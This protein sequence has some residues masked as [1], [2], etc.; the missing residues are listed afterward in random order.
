M[1]KYKEK[2]KVNKVLFF[3][4]TLSKLL[5]HFAAYGAFARKEKLE[6]Y[7][8]LYLNVKPTLEEIFP[9]Y[10]SSFDKLFFTSMP[11]VKTYDVEEL[12]IIA[13]MYQ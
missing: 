7:M 11:T 4:E 12:K 13:E 1:A 2:R 5:L 8:N 3:H 6:H 9:Q 10:I